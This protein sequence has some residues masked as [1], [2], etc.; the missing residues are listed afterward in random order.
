MRTTYSDNIGTP[1][2]TPPDTGSVLSSGGGPSSPTSSGANGGPID[3]SSGAAPTTG[4][5]IAGKPTK[6]KRTTTHKPKAPKHAAGGR[7][8]HKGQ[9]AS[10]STGTTATKHSSTTGRQKIVT[11]TLVSHPVHVHWKA[12][13]KGEPGVRTG[14]HSSHASQSDAPL[15]FLPIAGITSS[16]RRSHLSSAPHTTP[17]RRF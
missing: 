15:S 11:T 8:T 6:T 16:T 5:T 2:A 9:G 7:H 14:K 13:N 10:H 17:H 12:T 1:T 3:F 4:I